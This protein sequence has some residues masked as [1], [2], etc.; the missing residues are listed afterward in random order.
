M[1]SKTYN[2]GKN[3]NFLDF[4]LPGTNFYPDYLPGKEILMKGRLGL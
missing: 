3:G 2:S 4:R 1:L